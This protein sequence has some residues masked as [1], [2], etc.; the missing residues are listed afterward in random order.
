MTTPSKKTDN[1]PIDRKLLY[2]N[3][4]EYGKILIQDIYGSEKD[5]INAT[6]ISPL[7]SYIFT[8]D[9]NIYNPEIII[10]IGE[11]IGLA[12]NNNDTASDFYYWIKEIINR[13]KNDDNLFFIINATKLD[14][15]SYLN[16]IGINYKDSYYD[17]RL[18]LYAYDFNE[19]LMLSY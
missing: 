4:S 6:K 3:L 11:R 18:F 16:S 10:S 19:D 13:K 14:F 9:D 1:S 12:L 2:D 5:Y 7:E 17:D 15:T 8:Y